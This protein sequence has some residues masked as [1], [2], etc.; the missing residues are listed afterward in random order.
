LYIT[1]LKSKLHHA[2]VT[3]ADLN[4]VGS[5]TLDSALMQAAGIAPYEKV[6]VANVENGE[7]FETYVIEGEAGSGMVQINGAAARYGVSGD[8]LIV[9]AFAL[10]EEVPAG[11]QPRVIALDENNQVILHK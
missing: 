7:R 1:L 9:M 10:V 8:R 3:S 2:R 5:L 6:L 4:Y 11:W